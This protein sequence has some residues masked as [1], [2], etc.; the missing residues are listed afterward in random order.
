MNNS[1]VINLP[2]PFGS[3]VYT[4][5][6]TCGDFCL[7]QSEKF[8]K[9]SINCRDDSPCHTKFHGTRKIVLNFD[10]LGK[11]LT[12]W[13]KTIF[14]TPEEAELAGKKLVKEHQS[15]MLSYGFLMDANGYSDMSCVLPKSV[16]NMEEGA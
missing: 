10:T 5:V 16:E 9:K 15:T 1:N 2:V 4:Y 13:G 14:A 11:V 7:F 6:T 12:E 8:Y 3:T